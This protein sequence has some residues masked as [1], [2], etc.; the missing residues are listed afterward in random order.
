MYSISQYSLH[1]T[2][3]IIIIITGLVSASPSR[4]S[5]ENK[6]SEGK[7]H[8]KKHKKRSNSSDLREP[9]ELPDEGWDFENKTHV[10]T[11]RILFSKRTEKGKRPYM[12]RIF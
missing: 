9:N 3:T 4:K 11:R 6:E 1:N 5:K 8:V 12:V 10:D 2:N 7:S